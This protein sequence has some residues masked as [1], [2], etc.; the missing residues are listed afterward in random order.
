MEKSKQKKYRELEG[1]SR[2]VD[3]AI[4]DTDGVNTQFIWHKV[5]SI[6]AIF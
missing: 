1:R 6:K 5:D 4:H 3:I 2:N